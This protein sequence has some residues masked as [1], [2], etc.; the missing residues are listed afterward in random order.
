MRASIYES[1]ENSLSFS[2][3]NVNLHV[4]SSV[5]ATAEIIYRTQMIR[6]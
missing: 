3:Q 1:P 6:F 5:L 4:I 2:P